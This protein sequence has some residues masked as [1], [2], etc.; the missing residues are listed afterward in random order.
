MKVLQIAFVAVLSLGINVH[1]GIFDGFSKKEA[2]IPDFVANHFM[3]QPFSAISPQYKNATEKTTCPSHIQNSCGKGNRCEC[4]R[5]VVRSYADNS[6][7]IY[8]T[9]RDGKIVEYSDQ[10]SS[11]K[12]FGLEKVYPTVKS[13]FGSTEPTEVF[14]FRD[15][16]GYRGFSANWVFDGGYATGSILCKLEKIAGATS[17]SVPLSQCL[18][19]AGQITLLRSPEK[20]TKKP[21]H[22]KY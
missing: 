7:I 16:Y 20:S 17:V 13:F 4:S 11:S 6:Q 1:A 5:I 10:I 12:T 15:Q 18:L 19:Q 3:N 2:V 8:V 21:V 14:Q 9:V 22:V